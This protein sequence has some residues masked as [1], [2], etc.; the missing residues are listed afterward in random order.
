MLRAAAPTVEQAGA[1]AEV[2][3]GP[4]FLW[5]NYPVNDYDNTAG[6]L[7]LAS[8]AKRVAG[9][10]DHL[11]C[12]VSNPMNQAAASKVAIFGFADVTWNDRA[13][14]PDRSW[15][16]AMGYL[17]SGDRRAAEALL[18]FGDL[19]HMAPTFDTQPWQP[20]APH[21]AARVA[22][23][24]STWDSGERQ[25]AIAAL[26]GYAERI[27]AAPEM[28]RAGA[29][30]PAFVS[31]ARPWLEATDLWGQSFLQS[32]EALHAH[33]D[34]DSARAMALRQSAV[35]LAVQA[36]D[37][38]VQPPDNRWN[39][40]RVKIADGVLDEFLQST[41]DLIDSSARSGTH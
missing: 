5:D 25:R 20:Q 15:R 11:A 28:I 34:G 36:A 30:E 23:F 29:V 3:G 21:L 22:K 32:L 40:A 24:H 27:A 38:R 18:V 35:D 12:I 2:F 14:A 31:D 10:S 17:A 7:L 41:W 39:A 6:R 33:L 9:L 4:T 26:R 19:N 13:Y 1:A 8:Y 37:V 16:G